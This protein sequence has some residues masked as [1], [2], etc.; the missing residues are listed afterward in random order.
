MNKELWLKAAKE[1]G[2]EDFEIYEQKSKSTSI[3]VYEGKTDRYTISECNGIAVRGI[4][5]GN[6]GIYFLEQ[7][8]DELMQHAISQV[9][10]NAEAITSEDVVDIY[11]GDEHYPVLEERRCT[12][13]DQKDEAKIEFLKEIES[14]LK[15]SDKRISQV[16]SVSYGEVSVQTAIDNT[17]GVHL[18]D[19]RH[20]AFISAGVMAKEQEDTK[21]AYDWK[22]IYDLADLNVKDF[23]QN[24]SKKVI[25]KLHAESV[26]SATYPVLIDREAMADIL[27][28]FCGMFDGENAHKG[29]SLLHGRMEEKIFS[30]DITVIDDPFMKDGYNCR[31]FDDEGV[32]CQKTVLIENGVLKSYL[33]DLKSA[34]LMDCKTTGNGFKGGYST[35]VGIAPTNLYI[36]NGKHSV[37]EMIASMDKGIIITEVTGLHAGLRPLTGDFSL[38]SEGWYVENGKK[39]RPVNLITIAGN[40]MNAMKDIA[41]V[42]ND[43]KLNADAVGSPSIL[44]KGLAVSGN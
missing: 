29:I 13:I 3:R 37:E 6:M 44:F 12:L 7:D 21:V 24:L 32:A 43:M 31:S 39:V 11:P 23:S 22:Y 5:A 27:E 28:A 42:G 33:H 2:I 38:Q 17:K 36:Q 16:M 26:E 35:N 18:Q 4:Y 25:D 30:E 19:E 14:Q 20:V 41:M 9:K 1:E 8:N 10:E 40:F 34:R 15:E